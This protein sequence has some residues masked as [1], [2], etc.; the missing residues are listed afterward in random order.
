[1]QSTEQQASEVTDEELMVLS[2]TILVA[3][4]KNGIE[5]AEETTR[6]IDKLIAYC[7]KELNQD[8]KLPQ[9][10]AGWR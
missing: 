5:M 2:T 1:M 10:V 7:Q 8:R 3:R 6:A 9:R 4:R